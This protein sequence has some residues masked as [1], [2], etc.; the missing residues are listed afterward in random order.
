MRNGIIAHILTWPSVLYVWNMSVCWRIHPYIL[1]SWTLNFTGWIYIQLWSFIHWFGAQNGKKHRW[2]SITGVTFSQFQ[3]LW[4]K[5]L[6]MLM[7]SWRQITKVQYF[8]FNK[9]RRGQSQLSQLTSQLTG[10]IGWRREGILYRRQ[11]LF[12]DVIENISLLMSASGNQR[13]TILIADRGTIYQFSYITM[14]PLSCL[15]SLP[16]TT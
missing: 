14:L 1:N 3:C 12:L 8:L 9:R 7:I 15:Y 4:I 5:L 2:S 6:I 11:E 16:P 10:K 13:T